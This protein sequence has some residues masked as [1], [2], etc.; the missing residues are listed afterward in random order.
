[1]TSH[2]RVLATINRQPVDRIPV[3]VWL[4]PEVLAQAAA[5]R[6]AIFGQSDLDQMRR[7]LD[8]RFGGQA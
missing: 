2:D 1:M 4:T 3:D 6:D 8:R 7:E 5:A